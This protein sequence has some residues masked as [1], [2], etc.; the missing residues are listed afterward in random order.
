MAGKDVKDTI[1]T[2]DALIETAVSLPNLKQA[3]QYCLG[4]MQ[5][6][7]TPEEEVN[8]FRTKANQLREKFKTKEE[9]NNETK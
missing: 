8:K 6:R 1:A 5:E 9:V 2:C 3:V 4:L 7:N